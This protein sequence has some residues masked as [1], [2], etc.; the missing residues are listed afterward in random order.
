[1]KNFSFNQWHNGYCLFLCTLAVGR[2]FDKNIDLNEIELALD[3]THWTWPATSAL[4]LAKSGMEVELYDT[5]IEYSKFS[6]EPHAWIMSKY[7]QAGV[8]HIESHFQLERAVEDS[9]SA[10]KNPLVT[11]INHS[12]EFDDI[13]AR[14]TDPDSVFI[15]CLNYDTIFDTHFGRMGHYFLVRGELN[16]SLVVVEPLHKQDIIITHELY[17]KAQADL[18]NEIQHFAIHKKSE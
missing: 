7:G 8:D 10:V 9:V 1:M 15:L 16:N 13:L 18:D 2:Y 3:A 14:S 17:I 4:A 5:D 12:I 6:K 11:F